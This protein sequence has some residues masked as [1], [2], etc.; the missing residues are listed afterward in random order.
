M[1]AE[2]CRVGGREGAP[3]VGG[4]S[5]PGW[6]AGTPVGD[7]GPL[8]RDG[9]ARF[10]VFH[11]AW[12][13]PILLLP[14]L[15]GACNPVYVLKVGVQQA[16]ILAARTPIPEVVAD[17]ATDED[18]RGKLLLV[19]E[20]REWARDVLGLDVGT[21]YTTFVRMPS[22]T[23]SHILSAA[24]QDRFAARTWWFPVVGRMPYKGYFDLEDARS[25][26]RSLEQQGFDTWIR[27]TS[28]YSTLGWFSDP[29]MSTLLRYDNVGLVETIL[30]EIS[31]QHLFVPGNGRFNESFA[32]WV[33]NA[34]AIRFFCEREG[35]GP[36]SVWC[37][38]AR[39][40]WKDAMRFSVFLDGMVDDLTALYADG[41]LDTPAILR[42]R[43][44]VF[45]RSLEE[46]RTTVQPG[47]LASTYGTFLTTPLNNATL[48]SRMLYYHRLPDFQALQEAHGGDLR[49]AVESLRA[50]AD[51]G[52]NP[53]DALPRTGSPAAGG[54]GP[55]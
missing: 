22:D 31:H 44:E 35:G 53:F 43:E 14:L 39:E 52:R 36:D 42:G 54:K 1:E 2:G 50:A 55:G 16:R 33:G 24:Y 48:L 4:A 12:I 3:P 47:F 25:A 9:G 27:P 51:G 15:L 5:A 26:A 32:T 8:A 49:S 40:R 6:A 46:F 19:M 28:A 20:A 45:A 29:V 18:T 38:R 30:H 11:K 10:P 13:L 34:A 41:T 17:P 37:N 7:A 21:S 23:L